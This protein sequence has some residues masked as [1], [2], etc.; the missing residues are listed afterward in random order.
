M[1]LVAG[2][3][4]LLAAF[5]AAA[6]ALA[7]GTLLET[8]RPFAGAT[9]ASGW[10][11]ASV[12]PGSCWTGSLAIDRP[13]AYRCF[14]GNAILDPCFASPA[15]RDW[16][17]CVPRPWTHEVLRLN[18]TGRLPAA[19]VGSHA[20]RA[21]WAVQVAGGA[22]CTASTGALGVIQ[23]RVPRYACS[24]GA[25]LGTKIHQ[26]APRWWAWYLL[27]GGTWQHRFV[28]RAWF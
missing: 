18:L 1:R 12:A 26:V 9:L 13:D 4:I 22:T 3:C 5:L 21:P 8:V 15:Q 2:T 28:T 27:R 19:Q 23:G 6:P 20:A 24:N 17:A 25:S 7:G 14:R 16:V 10:S 11:V